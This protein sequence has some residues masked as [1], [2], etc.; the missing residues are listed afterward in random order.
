MAIDRLPGRGES[1]GAGSE[2]ESGF[3]KA[4]DA[5]SP[6]RDAGLPPTQTE[7][8]VVIYRLRKLADLIYKGES[9]L[10]VFKF[11][12]FFEVPIVYHFPV[13]AEFFMKAL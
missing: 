13:G 1:V 4:I 10:E 3:R 11:V 6:D 8:R 9:R 2:Y 7:V 5:V 12:L